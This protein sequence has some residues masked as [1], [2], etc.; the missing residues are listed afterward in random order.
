MRL[1]HLEEELA[2]CALNR[3]EFCIFGFLLALN[4][5]NQCSSLHRFTSSL[6]GDSSGNLL[7]LPRIPSCGGVSRE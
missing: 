3:L 7:F 1:C 6:T 4:F 5:A 2:V